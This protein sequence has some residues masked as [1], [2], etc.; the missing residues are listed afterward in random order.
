MK[1]TTVDRHAFEFNYPTLDTLILVE[2]NEADVVV[3][4]TRN[5]FS[6]ERKAAFLRE[7][8]SEGFVSEKFLWAN[9]GAGPGR[10]HVHW[11]ID[12]TWPQVSE[13]V[14]RQSRKF[15]LTLLSSVSLVW[16]IMMIVLFSFSR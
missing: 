15:M 14:L 1:T 12:R 2:E 5:T 4:A 6:M 7:L 10:L 16:L 11:L 9:L 8:V 3:R 13:Q